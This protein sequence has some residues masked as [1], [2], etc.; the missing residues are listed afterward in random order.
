[1]FNILSFFRI[2][3]TKY[4]F[5][6]TEIRYKEA[7]KEQR[8]EFI[9]ILEKLKCSNPNKFVVY[10]DETG[11]DE[12]LFR[13][14]VRAKKGVKVYTDVKGRKF[15]RVSIVA[16]KYGETV[17]APMVYN[18]TATAVFFEDWFEKHLC[19]KI[20]GNIVIMDNASIHRKKKLNEIAE[21]FNV[22][23]LFQPAYSP[24]LNKI[25]KFWS[26]LKKE[27]RNVIKNHTSLFDAIMECFQTK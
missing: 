27:L 2:K 11:I 23:L 4:N 14:N 18:G 7:N 15:E 3:K 9:K 19:P 6:K 24:D 26:L 25:E 22:I 5:K 1:M 21:K 13:E 20:S 12:Y 10:V 17:V 16:G 8:E